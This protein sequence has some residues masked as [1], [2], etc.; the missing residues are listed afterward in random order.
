[1]DG[2]PPNSGLA[3]YYYLAL[4]S[5]NHL[6][7]L[8]GLLRTSTRQPLKI[9]KM[10]SSQ[11][12]ETRDAGLSSSAIEKGTSAVAPAVGQDAVIQATELEVE[13]TI[14]KDEEHT[15]ASFAH[16]IVGSTSTPTPSSLTGRLEDILVW[17]AV[18]LCLPRCWSRGSNGG[19]NRKFEC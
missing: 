5:A 15:N 19:R 13:S 12:L 16:F 17:G 4:F 7:V 11:D 18:G 10:G 2:R 6:E 3:F 1:M 8:Y 9:G 14:E